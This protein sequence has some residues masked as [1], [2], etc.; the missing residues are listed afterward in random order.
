MSMS[1]GSVSD[2]IRLR[3]IKSTFKENLALHEGYGLNIMQT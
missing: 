2:S 3:V 1:I